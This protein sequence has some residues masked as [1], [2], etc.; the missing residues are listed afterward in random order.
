MLVLD[1]LAENQISNGVQVAETNVTS[2]TWLQLQ[3]TATSTQ[4][5]TYASVVDSWVSSNLHLSDSIS[6]FSAKYVLGTICTWTPIAELL[7]HGKKNFRLAVNP[8]RW[9]LPIDAPQ[10]IEFKK[11]G[12]PLSDLPDQVDKVVD[13][14]TPTPLALLRELGIEIDPA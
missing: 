4:E 5:D 6:M 11:Q 7:S 10:V 12:R 3:H 13:I 9:Y 14:N 2:A 1:M 8:Y